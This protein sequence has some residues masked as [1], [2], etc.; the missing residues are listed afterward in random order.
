M[1]ARLPDVV[2]H[3]GG[4]PHYGENS[5]SAFR[6]ALRSGARQVEFDVHASA[7]DRIVVIHDA[8]LDQTTSGTGPVQAHTAAA[9]SAI[10]LRGMTEG[11]PTLEDVLTVFAPGDIRIRIELK[12]NAAGTYYPGLDRRLME[13]VERMGLRDRV[14][15]MCFDLDP[16]K[17]F[18][19][20][21]Y[22]TS[23]SYSR[24]HRPEQPPLNAL[25]PQLSSEGVRDIGISFAELKPDMIRCTNAAGLSVGVW[26]VNGLS[27]LAYWLGI[28]VSYVLT[29]QVELAQQ[30][31]A[32]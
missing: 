23:L 27:R 22:E 4:T 12:K 19:R 17:P 1:P 18:C 25:L 28:P 9:L 8:T 20:A 3:R 16:L 30:L 6:W 29:D 10:P 11:V 24:V 21:G 5:L 15:I 2:A 26:T 31:R 14:V 13:T 32:R 7:D